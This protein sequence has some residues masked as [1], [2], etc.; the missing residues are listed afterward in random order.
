MNAQRMPRLKQQRSID[1]R[2]AIL[3]GAARVFA[4]VTYAEA[5]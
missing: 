1:T 4:R 5:Q 3:T 2:E